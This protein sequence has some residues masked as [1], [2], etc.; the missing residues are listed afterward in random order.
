[1]KGEEEDDFLLD[2]FMHKYIDESMDNSIGSKLLGTPIE[3][4]SGDKH[5]R[6][7]FRAL[8]KYQRVTYIVDAACRT[9]FVLLANTFIA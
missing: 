6:V 2:E 5:N 7:S 3:D 4:N 8:S 9:G 1:M